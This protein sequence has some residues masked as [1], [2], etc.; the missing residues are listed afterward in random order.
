M[1]DQILASEMVGV[2]VLDERLNLYGFAENGLSD[3]IRTA[4]IDGLEDSWALVGTDAGP[5]N[6]LIG[7][8][9]DGILDAAVFS[10]LRI[11]SRPRGGQSAGTTIPDT[12]DP[13]GT[14]SSI[15]RSFRP[16]QAVRR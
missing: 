1:R 12:Y 10:D 4:D 8:A 15:G 3:E 2:D 14:R 9:G 16:Y 5:S 7:P 13:Y 6:A 11:I